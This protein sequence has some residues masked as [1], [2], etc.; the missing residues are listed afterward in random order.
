MKNY[1]FYEK[2][3][4]YFNIFYKNKKNYLFKKDKISKESLINKIFIKDDIYNFQDSAD[5][6]SKSLTISNE[7]YIFVNF[8]MI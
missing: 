6:H 2:N 1:F 4:K 3:I 7:I 8:L 5:I